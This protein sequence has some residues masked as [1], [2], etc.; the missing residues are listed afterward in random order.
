M[1]LLSEDLHAFPSALDAPLDQDIIAIGGDLHPRRLLLAYS[2]GIFPW[3]NADETPILWQSPHPRFVLFPELLRVNRSLRRALNKSTLEIRFNTAFEEVLRRCAD[4]PRADQEGTWLNPELRAALCSL[5]R[6]GYAHSAE[7]WRGD[8]LVG[9]LYGL[10]LGGVFFGES[11]FATEPNA[12]K[13]T[14][15]KLIESLRE[16]GYALIDCQAYTDYLASFG[17]VEIHRERFLTMLSD[18][19]GTRPTSSWPSSS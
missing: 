17:A 18:L 14:F 15:V 9:G 5:H 7:A 4:T 10:T 1:I 19:L 13:I 2:L 12:S 6:A 11:M 3:Y 16:L 8:Q